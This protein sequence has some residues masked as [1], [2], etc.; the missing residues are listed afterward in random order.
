MNALRVAP[1]LGLPLDAVTETFGILAVRGAG[2]S[3][4]A[5]VMAEEMFKAKLPFVVVD[6]ARAWWGLRVAR[7]GRDPGL[8]IPI[9]G[10]KH[11]DIPLDRSSGA[12]MADLVVDQR[13]TCVLDIS[14]FPSESARTQFLTDFARRL[15]DRN[16][17]P[18]HLFLEEA[19]EYIPQVP[20]GDE[21]VL[22]RAWSNIVR[23]GR[24]RGIG[25]TLIT[26]RSAVVNKNVLTQVQTLIPMRTSGPQD[27]EAI[28]RWVK[29]HHQSIEILESLSGLDDGEGWVWSPHFLKKTVRVQFRLRETYDSGRTPKVTDKAKPPATLAD[30]DLGALR[31]RMTVTIERAKQE[32]PRLLRQRIAELERELRN[33][34]PI[35][36][37]EK[38]VE[39]VVEVPV[40]TD[41]QI[42]S[43]EAHIKRLEASVAYLDKQRDALA[44]SQQVVVIELGVL[45]GAIKTAKGGFRTAVQTAPPPKPDGP[46][47]H[48]FMETALP[49][50]RPE[51][52]PPVYAEPNGV[53]PA[54][55]NDGML[56]I[57][58]AMADR[59]PTRLTEGQVATLSKYRVSGGAFRG[60]YG[61][62]RRMGLITGTPRELSL[63]DEG[64]SVLGMPGP[65]ARSADPIQAWREAL[66]QRT[67][68]VFDTI[69]GAHP[70]GIHLDEVKRQTNYQEGGAFRKHIGILRRNDL[71]TKEGD[72]VRASD[73][74][75][76][77]HR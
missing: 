51:P 63:A 57:L 69:V 12:L 9:F 58:R 72:I 25:V 2:K 49:P 29:Y 27:I 10:G 35:A 65:A 36:T 46:K 19:D 44:Q 8:P 30:I 47:A 68:E 53:S 56:R 33:K 5:A 76:R 71:I 41:K 55:I 67:R 31:E 21:K 16:E 66:D 52:R 18:L 32:D 40:L 13:V 23:R 4:T 73:D 15:F 77:A 6:P 24:N 1:N 74:L 48:I 60:N 42:A 28:E 59:Y 38:T 20:M 37:V 14:E 22:L 50:R 17:Q 62:L 45:A 3:N 70:K 26:Q 7:N 34:A 43:L 54:E 64:F 39:K 61:I 75:F 11:G